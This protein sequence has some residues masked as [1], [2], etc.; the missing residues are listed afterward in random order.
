MKNKNTPHTENPDAIKDEDIVKIHDN[1]K[2]AK[3]I[4]ELMNE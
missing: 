3:S 2:N 1:L 4:E